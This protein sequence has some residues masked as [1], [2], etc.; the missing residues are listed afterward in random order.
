[1]IVTPYT[2]LVLTAHRESCGEALMGIGRMVRRTGA[3]RETSQPFR[4]YEPVV[5]R[6]AKPL[7]SA[8]EVKE[9]TVVA[10]SKVRSAA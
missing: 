1:M 10:P 3:D 5:A 2:R 8:I 4:S 9:A 7:S 6:L